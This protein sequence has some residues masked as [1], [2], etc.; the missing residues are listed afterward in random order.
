MSVAKP[1]ARL[2]VGTPGRIDALLDDLAIFVLPK[3]GPPRYP[4]QSAQISHISE[5]PRHRRLAK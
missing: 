4:R 5:T 2:R 3:R 1:Q